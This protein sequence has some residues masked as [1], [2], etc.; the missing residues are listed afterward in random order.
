VVINEKV[1]KFPVFRE[2]RLISLLYDLDKLCQQC[3]IST[4]F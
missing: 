4:R 1:K 2:F 3:Y